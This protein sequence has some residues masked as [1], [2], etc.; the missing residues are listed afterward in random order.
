VV[1]DQGPVA[2]ARKTTQRRIGPGA[3]V[4]GILILVLA[5]GVAIQYWRTNSGVD[6]KNAGAEPAMITGPGSGGQGV[7]VGSADAKAKIDV[8]VDFRCPHCKDFEE[9]VGPTIN[10]LVDEGKA[11]LTYNPLAFV[12]EEAS[13]RLA[14]AF[15]CAAA[16]GKAR[17]FHDQLFADF[18]KS[19]TT[20][21]LLELGKK[22]GITDSGFET[23]VRD[24]G[25]RSWIEAVGKAAEARGVTGTPAVYVNGKVL[26]EDDQTPEKLKAA[27]EAN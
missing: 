24:G 15:G 25:Q 6:L 23:C 14:N 12:N 4:V 9:E 22:L 18:V 1:K 26:P 21:Q 7:T 2:A 20:D 3:I 17:G 27:V 5:G 8:Y 13:P 11:Q 10:Q 19:W 16:A